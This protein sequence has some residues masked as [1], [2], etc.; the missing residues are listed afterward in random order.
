MTWKVPSGPSSL[1]SPTAPSAPLTAGGHQIVYLAN[2]PGD[3]DIAGLEALGYR[4][5]GQV[6]GNGVLVVSSGARQSANDGAGPIAPATLDSVGIQSIAAFD[7]A[8]K[9]SPDIDLNGGDPFYIVEFHPDVDLDTARAV[10]LSVGLQLRDNPDLGPHR[11]LVRTNLRRRI[12]GRVSNP[13]PLLALHD[14]VAYIFPASDALIRGIPTQLCGGAMTEF[15]TVGQY[16]ASVGDGWDGPGLGSATVGYFFASMTAKLPA[17]LAQSEIERAMAEWA[18]VAA[19]DWRQGSQAGARR[20]VSILF[21][22]GAHGD[23]YPFDGPGNTLA[24]TFYPAPP[25]PEPLAGDVHLDE[26]ESWRVGAST[27]LYSVVLHELG[28]AL[29]LAHS[30]NPSDVMYPYYRISSTLSDGDRSAILR[31]YAPAGSTDPNPPQTPGPTG[32]T[33]PNPANPGPT[34]PSPTDPGTSGPS[35]PTNPGQPG[36]DPNP[37]TSGGGVTPIPGDTTIPTMAVSSPGNT[38]VST[39]LA[40]ITVEG[41]ASD[42]SGI[43]SVTW[44]NLTSTGSAALTTASDGSAHW[45][46]TIPLLVGINRITIRA[47]DAAGNT[48]FR[49]LV[50]HRY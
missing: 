23:G 10:V 18:K 38:S 19:V 5:L 1:A 34:D 3:A 2:P 48:A 45:R 30:D 44:A 14:E 15:G 16:I 4:V 46:A 42:P 33:D 29:G 43:A 37:P 35:N 47:T 49:S 21:A 7:P 12:S 26:D 39:S 22:S 6:P 17:T 25:N 36:G 28:H 20:T 27:D 13:L 11:L 24:H 40:E 32:P 50:V 9:I 31:L 41:T 8:Q